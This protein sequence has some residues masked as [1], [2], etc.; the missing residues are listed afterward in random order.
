M[1]T[2]INDAG[3]FVP[4]LSA[5]EVREFVAKHEIH[6]V[7]VGAVDIDGV[8][9]GKRIAADYFVESVY[10]AG[11]NICNILFGWDV[12]DVSIPNLNYTGWHTGYPDLTL[13]PDLSTLR[14]VP[15][16]RGVASVICDIIE[17]DG[18]PSV[19][20]P[21]GLLQRVVERAAGLG[22]VPTM[23]YEFE[24]YLLAQ[25]REE[26]PENGWRGLKPIT[27]DS[28]TYS[29]VRDDASE[30]VIGAVRRDLAEYGISTEA[31]N[32]EHGPGQFELNIRYDDAVRGADHAMLFKHA[33]KQIAARNGCTASFMAKINPAWAGSSGHVHQSLRDAQGE[34]AFANPDDGGTLSPLGNQ[35]LAGLVNLAPDFTAIYLPTINSYKRSIGGSWAG[36][37]ASW[38]RDNRTVAIR[39]IPSVGRAARVENRTPG[40]DA[41][42]YLVMAACI[43]SG[44]WGIEQNWEPPVEVTGS[45]YDLGPDEVTMLPT[46]LGAA[47]DALT[48]SKPARDLFGDAFVDHF[49]ATRRWEVDQARAAV[50]DWEISRYVESI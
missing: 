15:W 6:T 1:G 35:Y 26:L 9:R 7:K 50:T 38:G 30:H 45:A 47:A 22:Y 17:L 32:T 36:A 10:K 21:R 34:P 28:H 40:A 24:F 14:V 20:S 5:D 4:V 44:L 29:L 42:P 33:V 12:N 23:A 3:G 27:K 48:A 8:W 39:S 41:N 25:S 43:A 11:T 13:R 16:E 31:S 46:D 49:V 37:T 18:S 2:Q 19:V